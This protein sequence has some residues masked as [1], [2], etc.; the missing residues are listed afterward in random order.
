MA[1]EGALALIVLGSGSK[2]NASIVV[3]R[4]TGA[5]VLVDCGISKR[6][7]MEGCAACGFD[8]A[9][10]EGALLTHE[11]TDH[12][13]GFGVVMRGL[14]KLGAHPS[15]YAGPKVRAASK[16][17]AE[18]ADLCEAR[19]LSAGC[20]LSV[21]GIQVHAFPTS[22]DAVESFGFRFEL[23]G[24][25]VGYMTD[26]GVVTGAAHEAL[27]GARILAIETNHDL[28]MLREGPYPYALKRRIEGEGGHLSNEQGS[29]EAASLLHPGL[30]R[31]VCMHISETNN[32]YGKPARAMQAMLER[33]GCP[34][35]VSAAK[36]RSAL[37]V[38]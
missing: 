22:H 36:Q 10:I 6:Q 14:A 25:V 33:A 20:A 9:R 8:P 23:A 13:K 4:A 29:A 2:G 28:A 27:G 16:P 24:D 15:V 17:L 30:E 11:H 5:G 37:S 3:N 38:V 7:F 26:T 34:A 1:G 32:T 19:D 18:I 21:A 31:I 12:T 35:Q